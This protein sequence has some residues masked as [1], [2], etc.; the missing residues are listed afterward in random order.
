MSTRSIVKVDEIGE[1]DG[2]VFKDWRGIEF[3]KVDEVDEVLEV[4]GFN[5]ANKVT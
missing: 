4:G 5:L 2:F 3:G 1:I